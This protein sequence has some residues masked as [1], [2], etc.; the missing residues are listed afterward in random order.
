M[1]NK[2]YFTKGEYY[3]K[4]KNKVFKTKIFFDENTYQ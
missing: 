4:I 1:R 2:I 3:I